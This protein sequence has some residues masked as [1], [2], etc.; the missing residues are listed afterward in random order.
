MPPSSATGC[1]S[2][3]GTWAL[4][5]RRM[6]WPPCSDPT[7]QMAALT[8]LSSGKQVFFSWSQRVGQRDRRRVP[9]QSSVSPVPIHPSDCPSVLLTSCVCSASQA[10]GSQLHDQQEAEGR[11]FLRPVERAVHGHAQPLWLRPGQWIQ[12]MKRLEILFYFF[13]Y[14]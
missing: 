10:A 5:C 2:S 4:L 13:L 12:S 11:S 9:T 3:R 6:T 7:F 1:T 8:C 14:H